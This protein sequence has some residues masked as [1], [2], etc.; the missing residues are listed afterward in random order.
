MPGPKD[1]IADSQTART[2]GISPDLR[3]SKAAGDALRLAVLLA[4]A[5]PACAAEGHNR[6]DVLVLSPR[7][8]AARAEAA[9]EPRPGP[10]PKAHQTVH[11][12]TPPLS[13]AERNVDGGVPPTVPHRAI[14]ADTVWDRNRFVDTNAPAKA[15]GTFNPDPGTKRG[16]PLPAEPFFQAEPA[17]VPEFIGDPV[18]RELMLPR[19]QLRRDTLV[20]R[21]PGDLQQGYGTEPLPPGEALPRRDVRANEKQEFQLHGSP[22]Y[23]LAKRGEAASPNTAPVPD[24]YRRAN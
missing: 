15:P 21:L 14:P 22:R 12:G 1:H 24:R 20:P 2:A 7:E 9:A 8:R 23:P 18:A 19:W 3:L 4:L 17:A 10:S 6:R 13:P 11:T 16:Q 5:G